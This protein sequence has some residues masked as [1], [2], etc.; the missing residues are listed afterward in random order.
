MKKKK[1]NKK[2]EACK[3][4]EDVLISQCLFMHW[5]MWNVTCTEIISSPQP[6]AAA[7]R[8]SPDITDFP[9]IRSILFKLSWYLLR[10]TVQNCNSVFPQVPFLNS[11]G[12]CCLCSSLCSLSHF[13][14]Y[15]GAE[16]TTGTQG[17]IVS[18]GSYN[19]DWCLSWNLTFW[20]QGDP[21]VLNNKIPQ[22]DNE[23]QLWKRQRALDV[24]TTVSQE[25][26]GKYQCSCVKHFCCL[27]WGNASHS[28][29]SHLRLKN[30]KMKNG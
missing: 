11:L 16:E 8:W 1:R 10:S 28:S 19:T 20:R 13:Y 2:K 5:L 24:L 9:E 29:H 3:A 15:S 23:R 26:R 27:L 14:Q 18:L 21:D 6:A 30:W 25:E 22:T 17:T 12:I 4:Q 7:H